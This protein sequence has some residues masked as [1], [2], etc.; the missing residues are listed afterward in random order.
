MISGQSRAILLELVQGETSAG[1]LQY[2]TGIGKGQIYII[3]QTLCEVGLIEVK[4]PRDSQFPKK[5]GQTKPVS[6]YQLTEA[7]R[8]AL[9][10][11]E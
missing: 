10:E 4:R 6:V 9:E 7:G 11:N 2:K 8:K 3:L 5:A 1:L